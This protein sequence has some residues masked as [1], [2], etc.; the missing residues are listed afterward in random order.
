MESNLAAPKQET[1]SVPKAAL[2]FHAGATKFAAAKTNGNV[3]VSIAARS[4]QPIQHWYWGK[5]VHDMAGMKPAAASVPIDYCH[6]DDEVLGYLDNFNPQNAGLECSGELV[7]FRDDRAAEVI[8]KGGRGVPYQASIY[9][10]PDNLVIEQLMPGATAAVNGYVLEGPATIFRQWLL[11]GVAV[12]PYGY[13][14]STSTRLSA[15]EWHKGLGTDQFQ[16]PVTHTAPEA[17]METK[18]TAPAT[19]LNSQ[20]QPA[21]AAAPAPAAAPAADPRAEFKATLE[22][23]T[24]KFGAANGAQWA[25]EGLSYEQALEKHAETLGTQLTAEQT[26]NTELNTKLAAIP[27]G[28]AEPVSFS[29]NDKH[30]AGGPAAAAPMGATG[31]IAKFAASIKVPK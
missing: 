20:S 10:D 26:K 18:T 1:R 13:D 21:A 31:A 30:A 28:E 5:T 9:F 24:A 8:D 6:D 11:R 15:G 16:I 4:G 17:T 2:A 19:E 27:R 23:F 3:P 29:T 22:K 12:C 7:P 14:P 25:A